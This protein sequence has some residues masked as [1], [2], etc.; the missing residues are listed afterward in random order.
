[1]GYAICR[2]Q[3]PR[4]RHKMS[5]FVST[6]LGPDGVQ[7][8]HKGLYWFGQEWPYVQWILSL[9]V[10]L[11]TEV[12]VVGVISFWER[13]RILG[14]FRWSVCVDLVRCVSVDPPMQVPT[15]PFIVTKGRARVTVV[16]KRWNE[17]KMKEKKGGPK[18]G[19]LP[20]YPVWAV[21][22]VAQRC[23]GR[24]S[25][26][27]SIRW[28]N[29]L[30]PCFVLC[31]PMSSRM[32]SV[33]TW[34]C[35]ERGLGGIVVAAPVVVDVWTSSWWNDRRHVGSERGSHAPIHCARSCPSHQ[36]EWVPW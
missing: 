26:G 5:E 34:I 3:E 7:N 27:L 28:C 1:L 33:C 19:G 6:R 25:F 10:L 22:P 36:W 12:F 15:S 17:E 4:P 32:G 24:W 23:N 2:C 21:Y 35:V 8:G 30:W 29:M 9:P 14:L 20:P 18:C 16:V 13:E 11:C 31:A